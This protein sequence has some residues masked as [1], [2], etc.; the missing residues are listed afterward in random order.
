[1]PSNLGVFQ[2]H[3]D[4]IR[5]QH[6]GRTNSGKLQQLRRVN[7]S[8]AHQNLAARSKFHRLARDT[9]CNPGRFPFLYVDLRYC[10]VGKD[11]EVGSPGYW[12]QKGSGGRAALA[13]PGGNEVRAHPFALKAHRRWTHQPSL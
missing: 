11:L 5:R 9:A 8:G 3:R 12:M 4:T 13:S 2:N 6:T 1:M 7:S 10:G